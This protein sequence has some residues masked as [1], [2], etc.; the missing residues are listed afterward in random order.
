[1]PVLV[2]NLSK[3]HKVNLQYRM[4]RCLAGLHNEL[5]T[6]PLPPFTKLHQNQWLWLASTI[7]R[8]HALQQ[9]FFLS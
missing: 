5:F 1:M 6:F 4:Y 3:L 2:E 8:V 9:S 7:C